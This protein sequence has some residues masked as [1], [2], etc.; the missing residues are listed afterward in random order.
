MAAKD[1]LSPVHNVKPNPAVE[2]QMEL[3]WRLWMC[4][5]VPHAKP[6]PAVERQMELSWRLRTCCLLCIMPNQTPRSKDRW[7]CHRRV[8]SCL[9]PNQTPQSKDRWSCHGGQGLLSPVPNAKPNLA[10][11]RQMS[12]HGCPGRV[13]LCLMPNQTL[14]SKDR[15]SCHESSGNVVPCL[16]PNQ[17]LWSKDRWSCHGGGNFSGSLD[18]HLSLLEGW[19]RGGVGVGGGGLKLKLTNDSQQR[20]CVSP[21]GSNIC[22]SFFGDNWDKRQYYGLQNF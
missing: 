22:T 19:E 7:S 21:C 17:T 14:R 5:L 12:Y 15:W 8:V 3:S 2:R 10:V 18:S 1:V 13:V 4:C 11:E 16:M 9:M 20:D 6:N